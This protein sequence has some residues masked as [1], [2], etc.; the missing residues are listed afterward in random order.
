MPPLPHL[1]RF[2][3]EF[4]RTWTRCQPDTVAGWIKDGTLGSRA[5]QAQEAVSAEIAT[6]VQ[7]GMTHQEATHDATVKHLQ[8]QN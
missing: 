2:G 3:E 8:P 7:Q 5:L 4:V 1:D 6:L